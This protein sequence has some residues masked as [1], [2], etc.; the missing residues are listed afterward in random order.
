MILQLNWNN[1]KLSLFNCLIESFK[2]GKWH[3]LTLLC[4]DLKLVSSSIANSESY[5]TKYYK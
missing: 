5:F 4:V 1:I 2:K 3:P